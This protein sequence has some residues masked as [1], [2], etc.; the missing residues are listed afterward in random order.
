MTYADALKQ[1]RQ[2]G[3]AHAEGLPLL[4]I[5]LQTLALIHAINPDLAFAGAV[6]KCLTA[7]QV[8]KLDPFALG[9]LMFV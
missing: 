4:A 9:D 2:V 1:S 3:A 8:R 5:T 6:K 7:A